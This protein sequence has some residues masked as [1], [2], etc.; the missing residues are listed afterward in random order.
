SSANSGIGM[1]ACNTCFSLLYSQSANGDLHGFSVDHNGKYAQIF[2]VPSTGS[3]GSSFFYGDH[4]KFPGNVQFANNSHNQILT[5]NS[6][7]A[8]RTATFPD[9]SGP[10]AELNL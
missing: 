2:N 3:S 5:A 6:I 8:D 7:T 1:T 4:V 10:V 9:N